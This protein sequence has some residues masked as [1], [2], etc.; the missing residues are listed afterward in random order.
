VIVQE[1]EK[2]NLVK[3][4]KAMESLRKAREAS[5]SYLK[6]YR[7]ILESAGINSN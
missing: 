7:I 6:S 2:V 3:A 1:E 4:D 5:A